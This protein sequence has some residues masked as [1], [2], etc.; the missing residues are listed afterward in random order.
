MDVANSLSSLF[1]FFYERRLEWPK[2]S[3]RNKDSAKA[4]RKNKMDLSLGSYK[5]REGLNLTH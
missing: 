1:F 2:F 3:K 5:E 4:Q